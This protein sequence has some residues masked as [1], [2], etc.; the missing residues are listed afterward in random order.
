MCGY[1]LRARMDTETSAEKLLQKSYF[2]IWHTVGY[3]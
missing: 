2:R 1:W 3:Q